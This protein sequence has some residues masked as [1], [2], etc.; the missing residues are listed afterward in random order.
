MDIIAR[1]FITLAALL[2]VYIFYLEVFAWDKPAARKVFGE[3]TPEEL[4]ITSFFAYNQ[5]VYNLMLAIIA[6]VGVALSN[7]ALMFAGVGSMIGA[8]GALAFKSPKHRG[9][10]VKQS[11][12]AIVGVVCLALAVI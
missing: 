7:P 9:A 1:I 11:A 10:A 3:A 12:F 4:R 5:G 6:G 8:A 2:H